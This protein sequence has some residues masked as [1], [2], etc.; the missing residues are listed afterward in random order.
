M[1]FYKFVMYLSLVVGFALLGVMVWQVG[2]VGL[3]ES[4]HLM[5]LW[6]VPFFQDSGRLCDSGNFSWCDKPVALSVR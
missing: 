6:S 3:L 1:R 5:G 4:C 2:V